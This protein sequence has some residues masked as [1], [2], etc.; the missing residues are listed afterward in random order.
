[1]SE[2]TTRKNTSLSLLSRVR[3]D[4]QTAWSQLVDLYGPLIAHWCR[5]YHLSAEDTSDLLQ[6]V[7]LT[8]A[9]NIHKFQP[10]PDAKS[11]SF[12]AWLWVITRNRIFDLLRK[13]RSD[14]A[15]GGSTMVLQLNQVAQTID[16]EPS[17]A[18]LLHDLVHRALEQIKP[19]FRH[20]TW[21]AFWQTAMENQSTDDVARQLGMQPAS[22]RQARSRVMRQLRKQ[23]GDCL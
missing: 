20:N 14:H 18:N 22:V 6:S 11:G 13:G 7:F 4:D 16:E 3:S 5:K 12:R 15:R 19:H 8:V 1:M 21:Q 10:N 23:L 9:R 2:S 17:D